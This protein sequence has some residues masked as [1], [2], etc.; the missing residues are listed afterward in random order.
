MLFNKLKNSYA[1][2]G[3]PSRGE[4]SV[5]TF[6]SLI[7]G[8]AC[9]VVF[10]F[11]PT[12][13]MSALGYFWTPEERF[14]LRQDAGIAILR[15]SM[16]I[17]IAGFYATVALGWVLGY[18]RQKPFFG[19]SWD[20][21]SY[22][23]FCGIA[24]PALWVNGILKANWGRARPRDV[25]E[26]GG[27]LSYSDFWIWSDQCEKNCS[28]TSGEVGAVAMIVFS[29]ALVLGKPARYALLGIGLLASLV[30]SWMRMTAGAHF[31]SDTLMSIVFMM[32]IALL[33]YAFFFLRN[34]DWIGSANA[35]Q[36]GKLKSR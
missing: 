17:C 30:I 7:C 26:F 24:G 12:L 27:S 20:K 36:Q 14:Y 31:L 4:I 21:W 16:F 6:I 33:L 3:M 15:Q 1:S 10:W 28:F 11:Y 35:K 34:S 19:L 32:L 18:T 25:E 23:R 22:L 29:L 8:I 2:P 5:L 9:F 13:D